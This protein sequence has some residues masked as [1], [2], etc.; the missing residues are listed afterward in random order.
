[1]TATNRNRT[2]LLADLKNLL[3]KLETDLRERAALPDIHEELTGDYEAARKAERTAVSFSD[4]REDRITQKAVAWVL[5]CVFARFLEDNGMMDPPRISGPGE[6]LRRARDEHELYFRSHPTETDREYLLD[7]FGAIGRTRAGAELFGDFNPVF[8]YPGWLGGDAAGE[9]L[10]FFQRIDPE[11]GALVHDFTDPEW[12]TRFLGDLYQDLSET[13]RK[14]YAL[15]QTPDFVEAFILDRTLE[16]ALDEFGLNAAAVKPR[17]GAATTKPGFRMID[18]A[19]GPGHFLL[20]AFDRMLERWRKA[21]PATSTVE[22]V[23][24]TLASVNGVDLNPFAVAIARFRLLLRALKAVERRRLADCPA[25]DLNVACGD[26]LLHGESVLEQAELGLEAEAE[27]GTGIR[28]WY[29]TEDRKALQRI[30]RIGVYHAVVANPPYI[31]VKDKAVNRACRERY[32]EV[33]YRQYSLAMPFLQRIFE[34][35]CPDGF[36][37][38]ITA[39][40][41]MKR[42]FGKKLVEGFLPKVDLTHVIDTSGAYIPG[43]GTPTVIL[44]GRNRKPVGST[45]RT[46]MGIVGEPSTPD[47]PAEG[48]V[49]KAILEQVDRARSQSGFVSV[50]DTG[51][52]VFGHHPWSLGGG[53]ASDLK[54]YIEKQ[55]NAFLEEFIL[56]LGRSNH[57]GEDDAFYAPMVFWKRTRLLKFSVPLVIGEDVRDYLCSS[58]NFSLF[59]YEKS[60]GEIFSSLPPIMFKH[61]WVFRTVLREREDYGKKVEMRGLPWFAHSMFFPERF[62]IPLSIGFA[63]VSTHNQFVLDYGGKLFNRS[64]PAI[65]LPRSSSEAEHATLLSLLNSSLACFWMKQVLH[66]KGA[67]SDRGVLQADPEKFRYEFDGTKLKKFPI[68]EIS[69]DHRSRLISL[70]RALTD[71]G[72]EISQ[73]TFQAFLSECLSSDSPLN[74]SIQKKIAER[75]QT[76]ARMVRWQEELDWLCYEIYRLLESKSEAR[77]LIFSIDPEDMPPLEADARPYRLLRH[78]AVSIPENPTDAVRLALIPEN[79]QL[80]LIEAPEFKRRWFRSAGAYDDTNLDDWKLLERGTKSWL[81]DRLESYFDFDGRMNDENRATAQVPEK[82]LISAARLA[83]IARADKDFMQV[84]ELYRQRPDF[85]VSALVHQLVDAET[86]P[87]LPAC[88]YKPSGLEK[89]AVWERTWELQRLEDA[90]DALFDISRLKDV[91]GDGLPLEFGEE[92]QAIGRRAA[93]LGLPPKTQF[94]DGASPM[95]WLEDQVKTARDNIRQREK[96]LAPEDDPVFRKRIQ[97]IADAAKGKLVGEIPVPPKYTSKDFSQTHFW[98]LR[99]KLDV[100]KERWVGFPHCEGPDQSPLIAWAGCD[101]LQLALA[102]AGHYMEV[103][104]VLGGSQDP[105]LEILL[106]ALL[107]LLPWLKQW[108]NEIDPEFL[109]RMGDYFEGFIEEEAKTLQKSLDDIRGWRPPAKGR[110]KGRK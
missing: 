71:A 103:K 89:R 90:I 52:E 33:C 76:R 16:P 67:T 29:D 57:T 42:E 97:D 62:L 99:G 50:T 105:R 22:L 106:A 47:D 40:S 86:V 39:N 100:P 88:R 75:D 79:S 36:T 87:L 38:Q 65:K 21:E 95:E 18:P 45:V 61:F 19:C 53:G 85:D 55:A 8:H 83:D 58:S 44:F 9:L 91:S 35:A 23:N 43:H 14:R 102:V 17:P 13:A 4:W 28:H 54:D 60:N 2:A 96:S 10:E 27:E 69:A 109:E 26:S 56:V 32:P 98:R 104:E 51:R 70:S 110:G 92:I 108:H 94:R 93:A 34:L 24:R 49:W 63:F 81:L 59:P 101:H 5:S 20:G 107:E 78:D 48:R 68:P 46:V 25:F 72:H 6:R 30:L 3:K 73:F 41:F 64:A 82:T 80:K 84:A 11:T 66:N 77:S 7:G 74:E 37:G 12:D 31:T 1:M 15:L